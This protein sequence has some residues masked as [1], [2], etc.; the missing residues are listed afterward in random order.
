MYVQTEA[1]VGGQKAGLWTASPVSFPELGILLMG[2]GSMVG[3]V[4]GLLPFG[5]G[6][7][8]CRLGRRWS[9]RESGSSPV[10]STANCREGE[11]KEEE[12]R[13]IRIP[14][15]SRHPIFQL[16]AL[17]CSLSILPKPVN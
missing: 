5:E 17:A 13:G 6:R 8:A 14:G 16:G 15:S 11:G 7:G 1:Q 2:R 3:G 10:P 9:S 12:G 4:R